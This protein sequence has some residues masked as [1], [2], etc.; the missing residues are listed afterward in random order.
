MFLDLGLLND[1]LD[2]FESA[3]SGWV[4][5]LFPIGLRL[6]F[7]LGSLELSW[8]GIRYAL[9]AREDGL[10]CFFEL[11]FRKF[12]YLGFVY[13]LLEAAP[14]IL[15]MIIASFQHAGGMASGMTTL[16]PSTFLAT[17]LEIA[18][19]YLSRMNAG[20]LLLDPFAGLMAVIAIFV[21]VLSFAA[22]A[23]ILTVTL[24][25]S[26][27]AI[28]ANFFFLAFAA[29]RWTA[30]L[31]QGA[32]AN[33]VRIGVKLYALY[34]V[35]GVVLGLVLQWAELIQS[36]DYFVGPLKL[37]TLVATCFI[38]AILLWIIPSYASRIVPAGL[39]FGLSP[40]VGD[41]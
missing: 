28:G 34:L 17:G 8:S 6:F 23:A 32:L 3:T 37:L 15:P 2:A 35:S 36:S 30:A 13:W 25:E 21:L 27:L 39:S 19:D 5:S 31:A 24:V 22:M 7:L 14:A 20:G 18:A 9:S 41:N 40:A 1:V 29:S 16:R 4:L 33:V 38:L 10:F 26:Y 12:F 11:A